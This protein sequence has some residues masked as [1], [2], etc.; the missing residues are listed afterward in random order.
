MMSYS[1]LGVEEPIPR[2]RLIAQVVGA[3]ELLPRQMHFGHANASKAGPPQAIAHLER[4]PKMLLQS[5]IAKGAEREIVVF[6]FGV[7]GRVLPGFV[8]RHAGRA[9][10]IHK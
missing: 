2:R 3:A 4:L 8:G 10:A 1:A 9:R 5:L 7:M 6:V